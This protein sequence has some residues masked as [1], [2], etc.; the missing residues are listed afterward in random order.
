MHINERFLKI[1]EHY[2]FSPSLFADEIGVIRSSVS[3]IVSGRNNP[4]VDLLQKVL[5][6]FPEVSTDWLMMGIGEMLRQEGGQATS[7]ELARA[8]AKALADK[9]LFA[10]PKPERRQMTLDDFTG[11]APAET[12]IQQQEISQQSL[13]QE[14]NSENGTVNGPGISVQLNATQPGKIKR[15]TVFY[16]DNSFQDFIAQ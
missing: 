1:M 15:I 12:G 4:G 5:K 3:H 14:K 16:E 8:E 6:R 10:Q 11:Q 9:N 2:N 13:A 7:A